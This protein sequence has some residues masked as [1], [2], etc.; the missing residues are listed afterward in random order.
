MLNLGTEMMKL[1]RESCIEPM[2][3]TRKHEKC[4]KT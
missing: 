2:I 4:G 1:L 3:Q